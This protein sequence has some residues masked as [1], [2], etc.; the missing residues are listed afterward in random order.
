MVNKVLHEIYTKYADQ[1]EKSI[2]PAILGA[3]AATRAS[4]VSAC[5]G[6]FVIVLT[7][8]V[9]RPSFILTEPGCL[10]E[11]P[12]MNLLKVACA[13]VFV[14]VLMFAL[15]THAHFIGINE[16]AARNP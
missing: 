7:L 9:A 16:R 6:G 10:Y 3:S 14:S 13:F 2:F 5:I 12:K 15:D 1:N 11:S 8:F 4:V